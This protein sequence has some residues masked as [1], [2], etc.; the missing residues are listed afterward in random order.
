MFELFYWNLIDPVLIVKWF[1]IPWFVEDQN[2]SAGSFSP[3]RTPESVATVD[4][5]FLSFAFLPEQFGYF[6]SSGSKPTTTVG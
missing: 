6:H 4:V 3:V 5:V 1:F 2:F